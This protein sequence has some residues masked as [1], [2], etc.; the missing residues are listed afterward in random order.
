MSREEFVARLAKIEEHYHEAGY[1]MAGENPLNK[2]G[3]QL[4]VIPREDGKIRIRVQVAKM[5]IVKISGNVPEASKKALV[6]AIGFKVGEP[7]N[8]KEFARRLAVATSRLFLVL[9]KPPVFILRPNGT[10]DVMIVV[11]RERH[12]V[13]GTVGTN[14]EAVSG[15]VYL[16]LNH[17][18]PGT[19]KVEIA[20]NIGQYYVKDYKTSNYADKLCGGGGI[21][22]KSIP[23]SRGGLSLSSSMGYNYGPYVYRKDVDTIA[24]SGL[25]HTGYGSVTLHI[26]VG[27]SGIASTTEIQVGVNGSIIYREGQT[28]QGSKIS[29]TTYYTGVTTG[30]ST[31]FPNTLKK[32]DVVKVGVTGSLTNNLKDN[33]GDTTV[34][35]SVSYMIPLGK[36]FTAEAN[37]SAKKRLPVYGGELLP[38]R[39]FGPGDVPLIDFSRGLGAPYAGD[40]FWYSGVFVVLTKNSYVQPFVG[41]T[42]SSNPKHIYGA[43][44]GVGV[45]I[46]I[47]GLSVY[48]G[49]DLKGNP[50][51][52]L[53]VTGRWEL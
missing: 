3:I 38:E 25:S 8:D 2:D 31:I 43:G 28:P 10:L 34:G 44:A 23:L 19:S 33:K 30:V 47:I 36:Y 17:K 11:G 42:V 48:C 35:G 14:G 27:N 46:P 51:C 29:K 49:V 37:V 22:I 45:R 7:L 16:T 9:K 12:R 50:N 1:L 21:Y 26:P 40:Y 53:G 24:E 6:D 5:G 18:V 13:G 20:G 41:A 4:G 15:G 52:G 32:G 39:L